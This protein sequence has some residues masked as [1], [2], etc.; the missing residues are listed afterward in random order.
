MALALLSA[1]LITYSSQSPG[2]D[3]LIQDWRVVVT[4]YSPADP[5]R[6][7]SVSLQP[8]PPAKG[9]AAAAVTHHTKVTSDN[10]VRLT[11]EPVP[12]PFHVVVVLD[13]GSVHRLYER[14]W[15]QPGTRSPRFFKR[16]HGDWKATRDS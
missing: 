3:V 8:D 7:K 10:E 2:V 16:I 12:T 9:R 15:N 1:A 11:F 6:I 13:D 14:D 5:R 4:V